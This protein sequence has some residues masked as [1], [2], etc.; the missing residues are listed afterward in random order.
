MTFE[1]IRRAIIGRMDAFSGIEQERIDYPNAAV[2]FAPPEAGL[3]CRLAILYGPSFMA[4]M[5]DKPYTRKTG[6]IT[7]QCFDRIGAGVGALSRL[8]DELEAHFAYWSQAALECLE[9]SQVNVGTGDSVG[10]PQGL[11]FYQVNVNI[12]FRAG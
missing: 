1:Q 4:G 3:W 11:G 8:A 2:S 12:R 6:Q 7:I 10:R 5:G 9:A